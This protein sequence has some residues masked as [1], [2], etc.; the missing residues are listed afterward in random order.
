M[1]EPVCRLCGPESLEDILR[2]QARVCAALENKD[3]FMPA[4]GRNMLGILNRC[5]G[6]TALFATKR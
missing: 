5:T 1:T 6:C 3:I 4:P 2:L